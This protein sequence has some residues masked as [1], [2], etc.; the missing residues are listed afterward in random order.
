MARCCG[1]RA[2]EV[3]FFPDFPAPAP[4][5]ALGI[6][7][8]AS[9][10]LGV[11]IEEGDTTPRARRE[12]EIG[13]FASAAS[14]SRGLLSFA[15]ELESCLGRPADALGLV[16]AGRLDASR[17]AFEWA[18]GSIAALEGVDL[19]ALLGGELLALFVPDELGDE[20]GVEFDAELDAGPDVGP[21]LARDDHWGLALAAA[22]RALAMQRTH[23]DADRCA[24]R[25]PAMSRQ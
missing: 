16:A 19:P 25:P 18:R 4:R 21:D 20:A 7:I 2:T 23:P 11:V 13:V 3:S 1:H 17:R 14:W 10:L 15:V 8:S 9:R 12:L 22:R 24:D 5:T 6:S